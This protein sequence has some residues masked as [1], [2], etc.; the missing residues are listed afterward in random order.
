MKIFFGMTAACVLALGSGPCLAA[1]CDSQKA[2]GA[3]AELYACKVS[4]G[5][6][7][8]H[9]EAVAMLGVGAAGASKIL[10]SAGSGAYRI[11]SGKNS[12]MVKRLEMIEVSNPQ[13]GKKIV[14]K[15]LSASPEGRMTVIDEF[16]QVIRIPS[17]DHAVR[18]LQ[19][20][21]VKTAQGLVSLS[22]GQAVEFISRQNGRA[23]VG[24][25]EKVL[26]GGA[27]VVRDEITGETMVLKEGLTS[28]LELTGDELAMKYRAQVAARLLAQLPTDRMV[29]LSLKEGTG[30]VIRRGESSL[31]KVSVE[32]VTA[33]G[34]LVKG[35]DGVQRLI[36]QGAIAGV[37]TAE[38]VLPRVIFSDFAGMATKFAERYG[39]RWALYGS[40]GVGTAGVGTILLVAAD[41]SAQVLTPSNTGCATID[42]LR[43]EGVIELDGQCKPSKPSPFNAKT[44]KLLSLPASRQAEALKDP[45]VCRYLQDQ[46]TMESQVARP[47]LTG[48]QCR[49]DGFT[50]V[51]KQPYAGTA[52]TGKTGIST[53]VTS[54]FK[55]E[56]DKAGEL[57]GV[58]V[59]DSTALLDALGGSF[60]GGSS[61]ELRLQISDGEPYA[62]STLDPAKKT[63]IDHGEDLQKLLASGQVTT[64]RSYMQDRLFLAEYARCCQAGQR[65]GVCA[66][67]E[68]LAAK[69]KPSSGS[70]SAVG[71]Q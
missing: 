66:T 14:G 71:N 3:V 39:A 10:T 60:V 12:L 65:S 45:R 21:K 30:S 56:Q 33:E 59:N 23:V 44:A 13:S 19:L 28:A 22:Q 36:P 68:D 15:L 20:Q 57:T 9:P 42:D 38:K 48:L 37:S 46:V 1:D 18:V 49:A 31:I 70:H 40:A 62:A 24:R 54:T 7:A 63:R 8:C 29:S 67:V 4:R 43:A 47:Q 41:A 69:T 50:A 52:M 55:V 26:P 2:L 6:G 25:F 35:A 34:V 11:S 5:P 17:G 53:Q 58:Q 61:N 64:A 27:V 32:G 51:V 16:G